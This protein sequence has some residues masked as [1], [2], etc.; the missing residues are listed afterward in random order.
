MDSLRS[1]QQSLINC[2]TRPVEI[3]ASE[4]PLNSAKWRNSLP[5]FKTM[6]HSIA[7]DMHDILQS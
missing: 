3:P 7:I 1:E 5:K 2:L 4:P 6:S